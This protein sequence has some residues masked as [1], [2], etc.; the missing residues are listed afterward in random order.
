[1]NGGIEAA[2]DVAA[3]VLLARAVEPR[4]GGAA[5]G[6]GGICLNCGAALIGNYCH[7]CGQNGHVHKTLGSIGHD[8]AH[9]AFHFEGKIWRTL[10][11][12]VRHP[13]QLTR[14]YID[15]ERARFVSPL[16]LF[17]FTVFLMFAVYS[18]VG[19]NDVSSGFAQ[20]WNNAEHRIGTG[21]E[22]T[23]A[24]L[25]TLQS[26]RA[27]AARAG[28]PI[29]AIDQRI[30][31]ERRDL[32]A[33]DQL[34]ARARAAR[35]DDY[36][37][38]SSIGW[39]DAGLQRARENPGLIVYK[40]QSAAYKYS[41]A[42]IVL[43]TPLIALLFLWRRRFTLYDH[44]TFATYSISFMS[45]LAIVF[46]LA[47]A[48]GVPLAIILAIS[49]LVPPIHMFAQLR[50]T[51]GLSIFSALWRTAFL[52]FIALIVVLLFVIGIIAMEVAH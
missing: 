11:M 8:L 40:M 42:L 7:A 39:L 24:A 3:G 50:G 44:A 5:H 16:A 48:A 22:A 43:S 4:A 9:G 6:P 20:G 19:P 35:T 10:P 28:R 52:L 45:L 21:R 30:V 25:R 18:W 2:G 46:A 34:A 29:A 14:R 13:G 31:E 1:M 38:H 27:A 51:Y 12:L 47:G 41:W 26:E 17:L 15:G 33:Y 37:V 23:L 32:A 36:E 49:V